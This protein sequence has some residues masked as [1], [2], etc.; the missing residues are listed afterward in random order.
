MTAPTRER[1]G[2]ILLRVSSK[3]QAEEG[4]ASYR[5]QLEQCLTYAAAHSIDVPPDLIWQEVGERDRYYTRD[6]L[7]AALAAAEQNR[8]MALIVWRLDRLT[9][10]YGN[11]LRIV[12]RLSKHGALPWSATEPD[13][14][15]STPNGLWYVHTKLHFQVA[16]ERR[17]L[18]IRTQEAR[19]NYT[20]NGRPW[21]SARPR[22]GYR[23]VV[24]MSRTVKRGDFHLP[25]KERLEP[26]PLTGPVV[27]QIYVWVDEGKTLKWVARA[28]SGTEEG[29]RYKKPTPRQHAQMAGANANGEWGEASINEMLEFPGYMGRW[30]AYR[31]KREK[32]DDQSERM[33]Q[34]ALAPEEWVYVEP[35]PAPPLVGAALWHRVQA[36]L[37]SNKRYS[38]RNRTHRIGAAEAVLHTGMARC[39]L[40]GGPME[41]TALAHAKDYLDGTRRYEYQ[42]R[43]G[44]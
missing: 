42:C 11:F 25:L 40:C 14:D 30:P 37:E 18:A 8:Y 27:V 34:K 10:D 29:G 32:R 3:R 16:P 20:A 2:A 41:V 36:R 7:Q 13:V 15:L 22:Y 4:R 9:D 17:T 5:V 33:R 21:A 26:D 38:Q 1:I 19:R 43:R 6:G 39:G 24:D 35:S 44:R 12:E 23:W 31:T 28:L